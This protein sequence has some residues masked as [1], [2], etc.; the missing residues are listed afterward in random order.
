M[1]HFEAKI[2]VRQA[3]MLAIEMSPSLRTA[4]CL[5]LFFSLISWFPPIVGQSSP[6]SAAF[7]AFETLHAAEASGANI[8]NLIDQY[9]SLLQQ[10]TPDPSS[11]SSI[12]SQAVQAQQSAT[13][14][15]NASNTFRI[16]LVPAIAFLLALVSLL[17]IATARRL[18]QNRLLDMRIVAS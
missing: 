4:A 18:R 14:N 2:N 10:Q 11:Y 3:R 8:K 6:S 12:S 7:P 1:L 17:L 15:K 9:N 5:L 13:A 16:V